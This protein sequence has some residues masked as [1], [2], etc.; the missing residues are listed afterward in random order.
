MW[1]GVQAQSEFASY[2]P[3][4][5]ANRPAAAPRRPIAGFDLDGTL[6]TPKGNTVHPKTLDDWKV[7]FSGEAACARL[8]AVLETHDV[9]IFTN[10][11]SC[12]TPEALAE[13]VR[14]K[15]VPITEHLRALAGGKGA[16]SA[17]VAGGYSRYR[18]P[19]TAM[20]ELCERITSAPRLPGSFYVGD[21]A[22]RPAAAGRKADHSDCD[23][24]FAVNL[25]VRF[26]TPE[27]FFAGAPPV[28]L[29]LAPPWAGLRAAPAQAVFGAAWLRALQHPARAPEM[30]MLCGS[31]GSG[32]SALARRILAAAPN[33]GGGPNGFVCG[34]V[35]VT[36]DEVQVPS[37]S[38]IHGT[39]ARCL[40]IAEESLRAG[41]DVVVDNTNFG[42]KMRAP[43]VALARRLGVPVRCVVL[44]GSK[45]LAFHLDAL[46]LDHPNP[47]ES[48]YK[49]LEPVAIH[50]FY[51]KFVPPAMGEGFTEII[52][53]PFA[54]NPEITPPEHFLRWHA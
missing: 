19:K 4:E 16:I 23:L 3:P 9:V 45:E 41:K 20:W 29:A 42:P 14:E 22:G 54:I 15:L 53:H 52:S 38:Y 50:A 37:A 44:E 36:H 39:P 40:K 46:R 18:K 21:A 24:K 47:E 2:F 49:R 51:K 10:Q 12:R 43:Y 1:A 31:P 34:C 8:A 13:F 32:K 5:V 7:A 33:A 35:V 30:T 48:K 11:S 6:I 28:A 25:A 26:M 17:I 27:E